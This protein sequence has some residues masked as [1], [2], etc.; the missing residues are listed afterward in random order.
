MMTHQECEIRKE[1]RKRKNLV[2]N[3]NA[4]PRKAIFANKYIKYHAKNKYRTGGQK[5]QKIHALVASTRSCQTSKHSK[6]AI[7]TKI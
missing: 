4:D 6:Q 2:A 3:C 1:E 5:K 7:L